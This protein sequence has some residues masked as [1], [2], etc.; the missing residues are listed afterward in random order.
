MPQHNNAPPPPT[1]HQ[2][3]NIPGIGKQLVLA[4]IAF[5]YNNSD[6]R[7]KN[8]ARSGKQTD[9]SGN[10][11]NSLKLQQK[12]QSNYTHHIN[13][14]HAACPQQATF[15]ILSTLDTSP[16]SNKTNKST[17]QSFDTAA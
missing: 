13:H 3:S 5:C 16:A 1:S 4:T 17:M 14:L 11:E 9:V 8:N 10:S 7:E 2:A 15:I 6:T 12:E